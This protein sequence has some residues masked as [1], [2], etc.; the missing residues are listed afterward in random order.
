[1][2]RA[3]VQQTV[4]RV[5][6]LRNDLVALRF[7]LSRN[8]CQSER[9]LECASDRGAMRL[10][11]PDEMKADIA[12]EIQKLKIDILDVKVSSQYKCNT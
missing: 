1:M 3:N 10:Q 6:K 5:D 11:S 12:E 4:R 7:S 9:V 8:V 2:S